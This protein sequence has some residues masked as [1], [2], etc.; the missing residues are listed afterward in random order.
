MI[1]E[2]RNVEHLFISSYE[3]VKVKTWHVKKSYSCSNLERKIK[4]IDVK[5]I[6]VSIIN[7]DE[8]LHRQYVEHQMHN[9]VIIGCH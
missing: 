2:G 9:E 7:S 8:L 6:S 3:S 4:L 1:I 5:S